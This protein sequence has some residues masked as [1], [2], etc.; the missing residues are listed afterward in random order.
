MSVYTLAVAEGQ[1][2]IVAYTSV[3]GAVSAHWTYCAAGSAVGVVGRKV[4]TLAITHCPRRL[5]LAFATGTGRILRTNVAAFTAVCVAGLE[6][7]TDIVW[8]FRE[9]ANR[10]ASTGFAVF[11]VLARFTAFPAVLCIR[12]EIEALALATSRLALNRT[13]TASSLAHKS[14]VAA[15]STFSAILGIREEVGAFAL[16]LDIS[17]GRTSAFTARADE[18]FRALVSTLSTVLGVGE[19]VA[20]LAVGAELFA[21]GL[22]RVRVDG[23][24][25]GL[26]AG[27][28]GCL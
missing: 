26:C 1:A 16:T 4:G 23:R 5:A 6:V 19:E 24:V 18:T 28:G 10:L 20:A 12:Q 27:F 14:L 3:C 7:G 21:V 2:G 13:G 22:A 15:L 9:V 8:A 25:M 11:S 17:S